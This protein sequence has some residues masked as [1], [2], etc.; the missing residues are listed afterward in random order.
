[1]ASEALRRILVGIDLSKASRPLAEFMMGVAWRYRVELV[2]A[3]VVDDMMIEHASAGYDPN[4]AIDALVSRARKLLEDL[5]SEAEERGV[6]ARYVIHDTPT[7]PAVGLAALAEQENATEISVAHKGHRLFKIIPVGGTAL[8][9]LGYA[10]QP[11][12]VVKPRM[13]EN[14]LRVETRE[15]T[16][17]EDLFR[18]IMV[19]IDGNV[20]DGMLEYLETLLL[21]VRNV[22]EEL[23]IIHVIE[24]GEDDATAKK[25]INTVGGR[26]GKIVEAR[27]IL[28]E[29]SK[30]HK[31]ILAAA[32]QLGV[33]LLV[34]GR[35]LKKERGFLEVVLGST[36]NRLLL[37]SDV[38]MLVYPL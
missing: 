4:K 5:V 17:P 6:R 2:F 9:L 10:S 28:L 16:G 38:P 20:D 21:R 35:T 19:A 22:L 7:D 8:S 36:L 11:V 3:Y 34:T 26:L 27:S 13:V 32:R 37:H 30:P 1:M 24:P 18:K 25:L 14:K 12:L 29:G 15:G 23:Y 31:E 33:T